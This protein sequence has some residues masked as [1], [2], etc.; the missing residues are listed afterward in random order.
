MRISDNLRFNLFKANMLKIKEQMDKT[1]EMIAS[2]KRILAPSDDPVSAAQGIKFQAELSLN[3]R[4]KTNLERAKMLDSL[5]ETALN[6]IHDLLSEAKQVAIEQA[7]D[8]MEESTRR[9]SAEVIKGIIE[10]LVTIGNTR[11][12]ETYI[13]AGK[14]PTAAPYTLNDDYSAT[15]NGTEETNSIYASGTQQIRFG[16]SGSEVFTD[17]DL[18]I[19]VFSVLK[20]LKEALEANDRE[21]IRSALDG[22]NEALSLTE[23]N[24]SYVGTH[25]E[26]VESMLS[27]KETRDVNLN[28]I[29]S[30]LVDA[31]IVSLVTE[32][33]MLSTAYQALLYTME[34]VKDLSILNYLR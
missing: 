26:R 22:L 25:M 34:K 31:D 21:G 15:F 1:Q 12:G 20:G 14:K 13:F 27:E 18:G 17:S 7:S 6:S 29:L 16:M 24:I 3:T 2:G 11:S 19:D 10:Q 28:E 32:L 5:Y 8:T 33:N 30:E 9:S 4:L 23:K